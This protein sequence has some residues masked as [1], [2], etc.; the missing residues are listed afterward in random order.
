MR[1]VRE[2]GPTGRAGTRDPSVSERTM[3]NWCAKDRVGLEGTDGLPSDAAEVSVA[4]FIA[5]GHASTGRGQ[6]P[7]PRGI[8]T[9]LP[10]QAAESPIS[11]VARSTLWPPRPNRCTWGPCTCAPTD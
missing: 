3:G 1:I 7:L 6:Q 9:V 11:A 8:A 2:D 10:A 4:S 5:A